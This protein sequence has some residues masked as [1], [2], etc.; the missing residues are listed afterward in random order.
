MIKKVFEENNDNPS[1]FY[2]DNNFLNKE[3]QNILLAYLNNTNDF[4]PT[5]KFNDG[6]SRMQKWYQTE[7][8]YFCPKWKMRYDHW[9]S[10]EMDE[11]IVNIISKVQNYINNFR[12]INIPKI[13]SCLINKYPTGEHFISPHRDSEL[14]FGEYPTIIGVSVG[15]KR[16][17]KFE[18]NDKNK[19]RNFTFDLESGS[20]FIMAGSSQKYYYHSIGKTSCNNVRYSFTFREFIL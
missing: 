17:I 15:Q 9:Q 4:V 11:K 18:R 3:E 20:L 7:N 1:Y 12:D 5:P 10:F 6:I 16:E 19:E 13:N 14:S 8:K 2:Y